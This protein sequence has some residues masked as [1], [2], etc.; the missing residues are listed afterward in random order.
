MGIPYCCSSEGQLKEF[1]EG[2]KSIGEKKMLT[3]WCSKTRTAWHSVNGVGTVLREQRDSQYQ[4]A[5]TF[6]HAAGSSHGLKHPGQL[7]FMLK[8]SNKHPDI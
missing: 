3:V 6:A 4:L 5:G 2:G 7:K 1:G 8:I